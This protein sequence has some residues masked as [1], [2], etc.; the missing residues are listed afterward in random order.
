MRHAHDAG[1]RRDVADEIEIEL[2]IERRVDRVRRTDQS[3][4]WPSAGALHD[5]LGADIAAGARPVLDD[6]WLA[7]AAPTAIDP[8]GARGCR[9]RCRRQSRRSGAPAASDRLAPVR[10]AIRPAA[11][12]RPLPDAEIDGAEVSWPVPLISDLRDSRC[13]CILRGMRTYGIRRDFAESA[14][15]WRRRTWITLAHFS[16]SSAMSLPKSAGEPASTVPPRSASR[17][18]ILGSARAALISLL[19]LSTISAGVFLGAPM[20]NQRA[21]LVARHEIAHG[22]DVRQR[23]RARRGGH[24]QRAQLAGPDVLDRPTGMVTN[25]TCTCPPSRSVSAGAPPR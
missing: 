11:R 3:S 8:S 25:M 13:G 24:R 2:V 17:A 14:R 7:Q 21:R 20:P 15:A 10:R 12:Q 18:L 4:V 5:R 22:R 23:L 9:P 6:E 1:D 16:V 19:S